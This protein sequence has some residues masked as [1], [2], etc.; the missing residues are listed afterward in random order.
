MEGLMS[1]LFRDFVLLAINLSFTAIFVKAYRD[2]AKFAALAGRISSFFSPQS[3]QKSTHPVLWLFVA[4]FAALYLEIMLIRWVSTEVR[5]FAYFQ[6]LALIACFLGFGI[7]CFYAHL[8]RSVV[9]SILAMAVLV[10][11]VQLQAAFALWKGL[12]NS[13]TSILS[14]SPDFI[15]WGGQFA[16]ILWPEAR[17]LLT[18]T[19]ILVVICLLLL[20]MAV[21]IPPGQWVGYYLDLAPDPIS[22]YSANLLGSVAGIW[23]FAGLAFISLPPAYWFSAA[24]ILLATIGIS[25]RRIIFLSLVLA[26]VCV[27]LFQ[28]GGEPKVKTYWTPYQKLAV[29]D[30]GEQQYQINVNNTGYM[31]IA[32]TTQDFL[33]HHPDFASRFRNDSSYDAPFRFIAKRDEV[34]IVGAG[35]GNDAA[36]VLR[37]GAGEV[38]TVEIDPIIYSLGEKLHPAQPYA[39]PHVHKI[40]NDARAFLRNTNKKYDLILFGLLDSHT[41]FSDFSNMRIDNYVYTEGSFHEARRLL[42]PSGVMVVK[43]EV[44]NPWT[45]VGQRF[46]TMLEQTFGRPPIVFYEP[47][48]EQLAPATIFITSNDQGLWE[49]AA[50]PDLVDLVAKNP[51][52]FSVATASS[53][54]PATDDW[55]YV[56]HRDRTI[57]RTY[58]VVSLILLAMTILLV[59]GQLELKKVS[60]LQFFLLGAGFL[61]METQLISRLGLYFGT[62]W[63]VNCV[64]LTAILCVL[65]LANVYVRLVRPNRLLPYYVLLVVSLLA[66]YSLPWERLPYGARSVGLLLSAA[67][68]ISLLAAGIIFTET[69]RQE[70]RKSGAFGA[71]IMGAVAGGLSQNI[72]FLTGM[73]SLLLLAA[74]FYGLAALCQFLKQRPANVVTTSPALAEP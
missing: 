46:Y 34:L 36:A 7:G 54:V 47:P 19:A 39:S 12:L 68:S 40:L 2:R 45:W 6:N 25:Q 38:D 42:K 69:F 71:N 31:S 52:Q 22:A 74:V 65:V 13:L 62:T 35:A 1:R 8:R 59:R 41:Q 55:P 58:L 29:L 50:Q 28:L 20:L 64:A 48:L 24:F 23:A 17:V 53:V 51:P 33:A 9:F 10:V 32:N 73:K 21:M 56:Y 44:R 18:W 70:E 37:N 5:I 27:L 66:N 57:P 60:T 67:Y 15:M 43:F 16:N 72:S 30:L 14:I 3:D 63:L 26:G 11:L 49:R 61:L 4:S